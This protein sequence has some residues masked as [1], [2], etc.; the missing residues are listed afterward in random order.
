V[1]NLGVD[2]RRWPFVILT[3][4]GRPTNGELEKH[5]EKIEVRVLSRRRRFV[6]IIDQRG[7]TMPD[8]VQRSLIAA[9]QSRMRERYSRYCVGEVYVASPETRRA[10]VAIFWMAPPPY[11]YAFVE[12][13]AEALAWAT[14]RWDEAK[15]VR[16]W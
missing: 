8:P 13:Y 16:D 14:A 15:S 2:T 7:G 9:H 6:Q 11:A 10:M 12:S 3:Y 4:K 1:D 5:L